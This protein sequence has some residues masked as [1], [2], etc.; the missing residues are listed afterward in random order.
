M[1]PH[2][3]LGGKRSIRAPGGFR[4]EAAPCMGQTAYLVGG[5]AW[6]G[7]QQEPQKAMVLLKNLGFSLSLAVCGHHSNF[8]TVW[9][10]RGGE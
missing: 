8:W 2:R 1:A 9:E 3:V 5:A 10:G 6:A 4:E 7:S